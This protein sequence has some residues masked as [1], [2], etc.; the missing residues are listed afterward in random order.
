M[1]LID[2]IIQVFL[3]SHLVLALNEQVQNILPHLVIVLIKEF[4]NLHYQ[5]P[6]LL[7]AP[8]PLY[9]IKSDI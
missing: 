1:M 3:S 7:E 4:V 6:K 8:K 2:V 5:D 9:G